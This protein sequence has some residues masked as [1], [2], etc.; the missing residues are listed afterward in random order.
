M[1]R[2]S[3]IPRE[4]WEQKIIDQGFLFYKTE[5]YYSETAAYEFT[6]Y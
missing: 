2:V 6:R 5:S 4:N 3:I 1:K